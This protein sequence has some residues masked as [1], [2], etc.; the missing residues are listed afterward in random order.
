MEEQS[1]VTTA[2]PLAKYVGPRVQMRLPAFYCLVGRVSM[3]IIVPTGSA[4]GKGET[5]VRFGIQAPWQGILFIVALTVIRLLL[6]FIS[7]A[8]RANQGLNL[9]L[10]Y[11]ELPP[12]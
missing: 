2:L 3:H 7:C 11:R 6:Y 5:H 9:D 8:I 10:I 1:V 4:R 12:K